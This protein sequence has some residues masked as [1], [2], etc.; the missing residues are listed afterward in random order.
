M[1]EPRS[2]PFDRDAIAAVFKRYPGVLAVYL[3][4]SQAAGQAR[5]ESDIDLAVVPRDASVRTRRLEMLTDLA[6]EG[7]SSVDL[8]FLDVKDIVLRYEAVRQNRV[9][10]QAEDFD[11]GSYYSKI[12]RMYLDFLPYL[13]VQREA[14]KERRLRESDSL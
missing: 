6:R 14:Y 9:I 7:F 11:R 2:R 5:A 13:E 10:Y 12:V 8:V 4:G 1:Q 3:F